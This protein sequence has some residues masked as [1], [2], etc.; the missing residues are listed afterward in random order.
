MKTH[1]TELSGLRLHETLTSLNFTSGKGNSSKSIVSFVHL[2]NENVIDKL[3]GV[4]ISLGTSTDQIISSVTQ[5][6]DGEI[7]RILDSSSSKD[8]IREVFDKE[9]RGIGN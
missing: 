9:E 2:S 7:E 6:K 3:K 5:I 8:M 4:G 1:W